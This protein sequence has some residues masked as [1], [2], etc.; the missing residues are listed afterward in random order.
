[1]DNAIIF[2]S[3]ALL[4]GFLMSWGVGANDL[5]NVMSTSMGAKAISMRQA[6][7]IAIVFEFAGALIGGVHVTDTVQN[8]IINTSVLSDTPE[9][10]IYGMLATLLAGSTWMMIASYFGLPVS[11]T[12]TIIGGIVGYGT[13]LLGFNA[14]HWDQIM[15][16]AVSWVSSPILAGIISYILFFSVQRLIFSKLEPFPFAKRFAPAYL[17]LIGIAFSIASVLK[18]IE[19]L[20]VDLDLHEQIGITLGISI[21]TMLLGSILTRKVSLEGKASRHEQFEAAERVFTPLAI[22]TTCGMIFAHGSNDIAIA[23]GPVAAVIDLVHQDSNILEIANVPYGIIAMSC[24]GVVI[25]FMMYG[26]NIIETVGK[27]ITGLSP[28]RAFAATLAAAFTTVF[29]TGLGIPVSATQT[30][31]GAVL[32][33]GLARG[34]AALNLTV[35]RRI[36]MSWIITIPAGAFFAIMYFNILQLIFENI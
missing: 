29:A 14:M 10:I 8:G 23:V 3:L 16:I 13:I 6:L 27:D 21:V 1:M 19:R 26:R 35:I 24:T 17:F 25:G 20:G 11:I 4:F 31:V 32:G 36:F 15:L 7:F 9:L 2:T 33:V 34:V 5:A 30:L 12:H 28:S 22:F 18:G